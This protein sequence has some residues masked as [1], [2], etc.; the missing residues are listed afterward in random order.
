ASGPPPCF[1]EVCD[2]EDNDCDGLVDD[3]DG[4]L[5]GT[6]YFIDVDGDGYGSTAVAACDQGDYALIGEDC[7]DL[8][9]DRYPGALEVCDGED[10]DCDGVITGETRF[11]DL[12]GDNF[13][14][15]DAPV[16]DC[17]APGVAN[18]LDCDDTSNLVFPHAPEVPDDGIDQ[19]CDGVDEVTPVH[20]GDTGVEDTAVPPTPPVVV[21]P[22]PPDSGCG[23]DTPPAPSAPWWLLRRR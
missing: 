11:A 7:D 22:P 8:R 18:A 10:R 15:P 6:V 20:T 12:D 5:T 14:D 21:V 9:A 3:A 19:D 17:E 23:C 1:P 4:D 13:G 16:V 2:G